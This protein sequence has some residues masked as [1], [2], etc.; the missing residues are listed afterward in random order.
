MDQVRWLV[1]WGKAAPQRTTKEAADHSERESL[2]EDTAEPP[3]QTLWLPHVSTCDPRLPKRSQSS[4]EIEQEEDEE[5][6]EEDKDILLREHLNTFTHTDTELS[7]GSPR[8]SWNAWASLDI[9]DISASGRVEF[10]KACW[11]AVSLV[12][13]RRH[14]NKLFP[15][16]VC[17]YD[18]EA[19]PGVMQLIALTIDDAPCRQRDSGKS[20]AS[21]VQ[22]V[23]RE[24]NATATFFLC[25]DFVKGHE[26][27]LAQL[28]Q[29]GHEVANH[30]PAD[31]SYAN[32]K[33]EDF[34]ASLLQA[35][36]VCEDLRQR[37]QV[38][39]P[40]TVRW[41]RAPHAKISYA[42]RQ[43]VNRHG[44]THVLSDCYANDPWITD[45]SFIADTMVSQAS[46]GS[47][48]VIHMPEKG[49]REYNLQALRDFLAG[50]TARGFRITT[51]SNL[52]AAA[53]MSYTCEPR[54]LQKQLRRRRGSLRSCGVPFKLF[55]GRES[56]IGCLQY[57]RKLRVQFHK[58][59]WKAV[60]LVGHRR[61]LDL[62]LPASVCYYNQLLYPGVRGLIALTVD[63]APCCHGKSMMSEVQNVLAE[64]DANATFFLVAKH[65]KE[66][67]TALIDLIQSGHEVANHCSVD[68]SY[69]EDAENHFQADLLSAEHV[70]DDLRKRA[71]KK[72]RNRDASAEE[73]PR[74]SHHTLSSKAS[75][76]QP[77]RWFRAPQA[78]LSG[79][80]RQV[81]NRHG[82]T[83]VLSDCYANDPWIQDSD[84]IA[85]TMLSQATDGS[86]AAIHMPDK[87]FREYNL[88]ALRK[89]LAG[90]QCR[91]YRVVT[92]SSIHHAAYAEVASRKHE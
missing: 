62:L 3:K 54:R 25:T 16:T 24:F 53:S 26:E 23:L 28:L 44:F 66:H 79:A 35:E 47:V 20:M 8:T 14:L 78:K 90:V 46:H 9:A 12:S 69:A 36:A 48:A 29:D 86:I 70:C 76:G 64:F 57:D 50:V 49:F 67:E 31:R 13:Q 89:F 30:C 42:M 68:Q 58:A 37:A 51:L 32:D 61:H 81:L 73:V 92:L 71:E 18:V 40:A 39:S 85:E 7:Q 83:H 60:S 33:A 17:Y 15:A 27:S 1:Q 77:V 72:F 45:P 38:T 5:D 82:F 2:F 6:E 52:H 10:H 74:A 87:G 21:E 91:G 80:M 55:K 59:C 41:F 22:Q 11:K 56:E 75:T 34:E 19:H 88:N 65:V 4:Y 84:C 63:N 43:V